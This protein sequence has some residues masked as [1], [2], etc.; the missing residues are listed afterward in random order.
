MEFYP[1]ISLFITLRWLDIVDILLV[2]ALLY[3]VYDLI[4]GTAAVNIFL[5]ILAVIVVW[6]VVKAAEMELLTEI[7]GQFIS[8]GVIALLI[9]FQPELRQFLLLIG[10]PGIVGRSKAGKRIFGWIEQMNVIHDK[11][12]DELLD[13]CSELAR[14]KE[15]AL[16]IIA[17]KSQLTSYTETG[18]QL[19]SK[20]SSRM[21]QNVFFKN[22]PLH[23]GAV[24]IVENRVKAAGCVLPLT[25][26]KD[27]PSYLGLRHRAGLGITEKSDAIAVIIS[28][29]TGHISVAEHG[30]I[31]YNID[32][33]KLRKFLTDNLL[34]HESK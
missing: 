11:D 25:E 22:S 4:K 28:E 7:L 9:V 27:F 31:R 29:E 33:S 34:P 18:E 20:I 21:L 1:E 12:I 19:D 16:I 32:L 15:G 3:L 2:A 17:R 8:V 24:V 23:D 30:N 13:A 6:R 26:N 10:S 5:G 14:E